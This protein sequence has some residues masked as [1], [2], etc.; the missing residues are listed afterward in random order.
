[1]PTP[2]TKPLLALASI[3]VL[4]STGRARADCSSG[5]EYGAV[6]NA[7]TVQISLEE[8]SRTCGGAIPML[9]QD[10]QTGAVVE[11]AGECVSGQY[12]DECVPPGVYHYGFATPYDCS[13][14]G[15]AGVAY[16]V[17]V[18]VP[19]AADG[20]VRSAGNSAPAAYAGTVPWASSTS[21]TLF[22]PSGCNCST[23]GRGVLGIEGALAG[24][25][26]V[27]LVRRRRTNRP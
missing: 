13:E 24:L 20:C 18:T 10:T 15:C 3:A 11:L 26:L 2:W 22:C 12:V 27:F 16:Y 9:R 5:A 25:S 7:N 14:Q 4:C 21:P 17:E 19:S 6:V 23:P 1:M 8:T